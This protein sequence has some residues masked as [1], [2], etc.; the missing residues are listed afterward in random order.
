MKCLKKKPLLF[1]GILSTLL[2]LLTIGQKGLADGESVG[3]SEGA[4]TVTAAGF[5]TRA[6]INN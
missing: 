1:L 6:S 2:I 5:S 4:S 3:S